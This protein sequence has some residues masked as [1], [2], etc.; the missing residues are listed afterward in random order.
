MQETSPL[1]KVNF[2]KGKFTVGSGQSQQETSPLDKVNK[3]LPL[4]TKS[5]RNFPKDKCAVGSG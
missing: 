2:L 4:W 5:T 1:D 3:K